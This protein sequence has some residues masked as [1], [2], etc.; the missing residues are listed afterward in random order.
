MKASSSR[1]ELRRPHLHRVGGAAVRGSADP[2]EQ[3]LTQLTEAN[4]RLVGCR[5]G[6][7]GEYGIPTRGMRPCSALTSGLPIMV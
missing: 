7:G 1:M 4:R 3:V 2:R 5:S 6:G